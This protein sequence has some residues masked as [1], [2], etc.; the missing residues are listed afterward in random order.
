[1]IFT[2]VNIRSM[3]HLF[4]NLRGP[5]KSVILPLIGWQIESQVNNSIFNMETVLVVTED[6]QWLIYPCGFDLTKYLK[7]EVGLHSFWKGHD[8]L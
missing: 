4:E 8:Q 2:K 7:K 3:A 5:D 1:M 6:I